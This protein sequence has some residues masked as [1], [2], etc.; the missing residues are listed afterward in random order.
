MKRVKAT[1][2][3]SKNCPPCLELMSK[4]QSVNKDQLNIVCV[5]HGMNRQTLKYSF[6]VGGKEISNISKIPSLIHNGTVYIG[7][8][9]YKYLK[10]EK[11]I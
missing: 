1:L 2:F 9:I 6:R 5:S 10:N 7:V 11:L 4:L 8:G 3:V